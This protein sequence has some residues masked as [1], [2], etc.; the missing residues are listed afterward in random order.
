MAEVD[1]NRS[2]GFYVD[3]AWRV[4]SGGGFKTINPVDG[5]ESAAFSMPDQFEI[6]EIVKKSRTSFDS[7]VW[8]G[9][10]WH[11]RARVLDRV[12]EIMDTRTEE[13]A[14][15]QS[16]GNGKTLKECRA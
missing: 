15:A 16:I 4:G 9:M 1:S 3:G 2:V 8:S 11:E 14:A 10:K 13:L 12:A 6:E 5:R 7:Q